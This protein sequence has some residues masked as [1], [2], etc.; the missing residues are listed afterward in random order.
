METTRAPS[1]NGDRVQKDQI[2]FKTNVEN[3]LF[4]SSGQLENDKH[5][6]WSTQNF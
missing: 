2:C 1:D 4:F 3:L 5:D 6:G